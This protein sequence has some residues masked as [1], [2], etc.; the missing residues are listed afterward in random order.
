MTVAGDLPSGVIETAPF[1]TLTPVAIAEAAAEESVTYDAWGL[2][3][4]SPNVP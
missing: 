3:A 2:V 1:A 4:R